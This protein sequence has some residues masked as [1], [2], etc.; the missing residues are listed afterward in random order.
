MAEMLYDLPK[1]T[2]P[3]TDLNDRFFKI[4]KCDFLSLLSLYYTA[5]HFH[6]QPS[7]PALFHKLPAMMK[8]LNYLCSPI[9]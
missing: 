8:M 4:Q 7:K 3:N 9:W 6:W 1:A 5:P 2:T